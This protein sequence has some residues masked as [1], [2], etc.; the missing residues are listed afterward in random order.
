VGDAR[1]A[2]GCER[3]RSDGEHFRASSVATAPLGARRAAASASK[4]R[5]VRKD[6]AIDTV[7]TFMADTGALQRVRG[8]LLA[9]GGYESLQF[10]FPQA[11]VRL[12]ADVDTDEAV[13][14][15]LGHE[16]ATLD[17]LSHCDDFAPALGKVIEYAWWMTNHRGYADAFQ[18]RFLDLDDRT[19]VTRQFAV[20]ASV[21]RVLKVC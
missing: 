2:H 13:V 18:M 8:R 7:T 16:D 5:P 6:A 4:Q 21:I 15:L 1:L 3:D 20:A 14:D 12:G 11:V 19:E 10:A 17:D 9:F